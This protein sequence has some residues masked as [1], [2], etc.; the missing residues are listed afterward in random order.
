MGLT[1]KQAKQET[2]TDP[3]FLTPPLRQPFLSPFSSYLLQLCIFVLFLRRFS[4]FASGRKIDPL[5]SLSSFFFCV[6]TLLLTSSPL[7]PA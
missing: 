3:H 6:G 2:T 5:L 7:P 1:K 4:P